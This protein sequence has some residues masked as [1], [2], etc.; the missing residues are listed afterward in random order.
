MGLMCSLACRARADCPLRWCASCGISRV[1]VD[2][3]SWGS[4]L[5]PGVTEEEVAAVLQVVRLGAD[6]LHGRMGDLLV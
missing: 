4:A 2:G 3:P 5:A 6:G 1:V